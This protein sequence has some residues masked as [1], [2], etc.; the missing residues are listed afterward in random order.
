[1]K[2]RRLLAL[3]AVGFALS[4]CLAGGASAATTNKSVAPKAKISVRKANRIAL[5]KYPG[6]VQGKTVL[7]NE[8]GVW[9]YAVTVL[10]HK[11]LHEVMVNAQTG[12]IDSEE[13]VTAGEE[14]AEAQADAAKAKGQKVVP[15]KEKPEA[16]EANE[17]GE[18][19][20]QG[21]AAETK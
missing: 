10:S 20:E 18:A 16:G 4:L 19:D 1:M 2:I 14:K 5:K 6:K 17:K 12:K 15:P 8:E 13:I 21:E 11:V 9:D 7:E 3:L